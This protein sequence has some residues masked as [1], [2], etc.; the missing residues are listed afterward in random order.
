MVPAAGHEHSGRFIRTDR[1]AEIENPVMTASGTFGY[2]KDSKAH[3]VGATGAIVVKVS[4]K[5]SKA[6][7][8]RGLLKQP[9]ECSTLS[10]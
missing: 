4:L 7:R 5:P 1:Q 3:A 8:R 9:A 2:G 10:A 6:I